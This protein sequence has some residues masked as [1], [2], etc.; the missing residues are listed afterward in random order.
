MTD[1]TE[2]M[3]ADGWIKH[4]GGP[5]PY[6]DNRS[7]QI[8]CANGATGWVSPANLRW[9]WGP[10]DTCGSRIIAYKPEQPQ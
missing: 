3:L 10:Q 2:A 1:K 8:A 4:D 9:E 6:T 5:C 7:V